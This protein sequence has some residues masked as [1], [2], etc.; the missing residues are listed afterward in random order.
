MKT[1]AARSTR[2]GRK[3]KK[4]MENGFYCGYDLSSSC[5]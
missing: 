3:D 1:K 5:C 2:M 4:P